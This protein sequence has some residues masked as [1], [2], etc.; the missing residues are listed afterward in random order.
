MAAMLHQRQPF[1]SEDHEILRNP[2]RH[3]G[4]ADSFEAVLET[5]K[6][7]CSCFKCRH[8]GHS[9]ET[10]PCCTVTGLLHADEGQKFDNND[11][12]SFV[13]D[14]NNAARKIQKLWKKKTPNNEEHSAS[15]KRKRVVTILPDEIEKPPNDVNNK[16]G[17]PL[18]KCI[19]KKIALDNIEASNHKSPLN[20]KDSSI[21]ATDNNE[22]D[23]ETG[24]MVEYET[25]SE[26]SLNSS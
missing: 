4:Q 18:G 23:F 13:K 12:A 26:S 8:C 6:R 10:T 14:E 9:K 16:H 22:E 11:T 5:I 20:G 17:S 21:D 15:P 24:N 19:F 7:Y 2:S 1:S 3:S 25:A